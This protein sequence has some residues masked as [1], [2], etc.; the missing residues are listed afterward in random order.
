MGNLMTLGS[1]RLERVRT[2]EERR[3]SNVEIVRSVRKCIVTEY[4]K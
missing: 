2:A 3:G 1:V 4:E